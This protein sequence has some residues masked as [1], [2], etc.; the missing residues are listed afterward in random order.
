VPHGSC[1]ICGHDRPYAVWH[2]P[3]MVGVC[4]A[5]RDA[6]KGPGGLAF[7]A[8]LLRRFDDAWLR[9]QK[10]EAAL[11]SERAR[12]QQLTEAFECVLDQSVENWHEGTPPNDLAL[13]DW[14]GLGWDAYKAWVEGG[15]PK[16]I[17]EWV[18]VRGQDERSLEE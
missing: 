14:S 3:S 5:C 18:A 13:H 16:L 7:R 4:F 1:L 8:E 12:N 2:D 6:A 15:V 9:A 11:D 10:A 17:A